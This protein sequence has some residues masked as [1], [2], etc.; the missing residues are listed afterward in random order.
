[1]KKSNELDL[2]K[3]QDQGWNDAFST[4][5]H[6]HGEFPRIIED[7]RKD[8]HEKRDEYTNKVQKILEEEEKIIRKWEDEEDPSKVKKSLQAKLSKF[9]NFNCEN[10]R[11]SIKSS[12]DD[13]RTREKNYI[14]FQRQ[15]N[16]ILEPVRPDHKK[17]GWLIVLGLFIV[18]VLA[19]YALFQQVTGSN[20]SAGKMEALVLSSAQSFVNVV[21]GFMV[22][23]LLWPKILFGR[24]ISI[25]ILSSML[26]VLHG[27][28]IVW[29]NL[30]IGLWRGILIYNSTHEKQLSMARALNP[31][32]N[33]QFFNGDMPS[34]L[35]SLVG[36]VFALIAYFDGWFSDDPYPQYG[37]RFREQRDAKVRLDT[38]K[39]KLF[40]LWEE[41]CQFYD[42][43]I[44]ES[45]EKSLSTLSNWSKS[46]N[47]IEKEF[48]DYKAFVKGLEKNYNAAKHTYE[49]SF[50]KANPDQ[51]KKMKFPASDLLFTKDELDPFVVFGDA[52]YYHLVDAERVKEFKK[53]KADYNSNFEKLVSTWDKYK[54]T[55]TEKLNKLVKDYDI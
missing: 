14:E 43:T 54:Q 15:H 4:Q 7:L 36:L 18:E 34:I 38:S 25:K 42:D 1:V 23:S 24:N 12:F 19:N 31:F 41:L 28:I 11:N 44:A 45:L 29:M 16:R 39:K 22:G 27:F 32:E 3:F 17:I 46:V 50:N 21:S 13:F 51:K 30:A 2:K 35:V 49:S 48:V 33:F 6:S 40:T 5:D 53:K 26:S 10:H 47:R 9:L 20:T 52:K 55:A 37:N 8:F